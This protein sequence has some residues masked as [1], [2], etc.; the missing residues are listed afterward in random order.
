MF[1]TTGWWFFGMHF[2]WWAFWIVLIVAAFSTVTPVPKN[3]L[4]TGERAL[5][6]L[7]RRYAAGQLSTEEYERRKAVLERDEPGRIPTVSSAPAHQHH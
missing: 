7:R 4:R 2:F 6:I 5:D 1:H 3:Q